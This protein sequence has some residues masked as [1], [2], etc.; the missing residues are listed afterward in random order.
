MSAPKLP[1]K[2]PSLITKAFRGLYQDS[3]ASKPCPHPM[4]GC[5]IQTTAGIVRHPL[6]TLQRHAV[7][8][9]PDCKC[10][11]NPLASTTGPLPKREMGDAEMSAFALQF[12]QGAYAVAIAGYEALHP[13]H[14]RQRR[15]GIENRQ[16]LLAPGL[17]SAPEV[18]PQGLSVGGATG[19]VCAPANLSFRLPCY[20]NDMIWDNA[21][22]VLPPN[23]HY[24]ACFAVPVLFRVTQTCVVLV[25][26]GCGVYWAPL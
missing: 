14:R 20:S 16:Q 18:G 4:L 17:Q 22:I 7:A 13:E 2:S 25:C 24:T 1:A 26:A 19:Q 8:A 12:R 3:G 10:R 21:P 6:G 23:A 5:S 9:V 11:R 15:R